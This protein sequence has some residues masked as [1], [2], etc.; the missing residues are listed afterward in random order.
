[1]NEFSPD[2]DIVTLREKELTLLLR[3]DEIHNMP[4]FKRILRYSELQNIQEQ[5]GDLKIK[6]VL[7]YMH[8]IIEELQLKY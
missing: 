1:M 2:S 3:R 8:K 7:G 4:R 5:L 6:I